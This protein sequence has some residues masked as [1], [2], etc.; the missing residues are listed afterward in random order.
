MRFLFYSHDSYGLGHLRRSVTIASQLID[1]L[2]QASVLIATGSP[3]A[4]SFKLPG[5]VDI[6]K[7][8]SVSKDR[9]G[10]YVS[11]EW[12]MELRDLLKFRSKLL[13]STVEG[14]R[15]RV[16]LVDHKPIGLMGELSLALSKARNIGTRC[17]LGLRDI[18]D[19][20]DAMESEFGSDEVRHSLSENYSQIMVYGDRRVFDASRE[21]SQLAAVRK[22]LRFTGY[23]VRP[24]A[25]PPFRP[26]ALL[27]PHVVVTVGGGEDGPR[28]V[29]RYMDA[30]ELGDPAWNST[31]ILG[32]LFSN[33]K[34][35]EVKKR[36][37][38]MRSVEIH[39][40]HNDLP[41]L[42]RDASAVVSM[43]GYNTVT[44][45][46]Q[47]RIPS[48]LLPR[49]TPR[50][51]QAVRAQRL[52][53]LGLA[54][55]AAGAEPKEL[56]ESITRAI[57]QRRILAELPAM[58]GAQKAAAMLLQSAVTGRSGSYVDHPPMGPH[59]GAAS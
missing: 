50:L 7:L 45:I 30:L 43:A 55:S 27:R 6:L 56:F 42:L 14:F 58:N 24:A 54:Q 33:E 15:P 16:L 21:Y 8:P 28:R 49:V 34:G 52:A 25:R 39:R 36:A 53:A 4:T 44:E 31:I 35:R 18:V 46:L 2:P 12:P 17:L 5:G 9:A 29:N 51:E 59:A 38:T 41:A 48:V 47:A 19:H 1:R 11:R 13:E 22:R 10:R 37:R 3:V 23:V 32:P 20:P 57:Q 26:L 40:T